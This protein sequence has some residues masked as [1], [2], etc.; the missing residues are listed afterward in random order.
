MMALTSNLNREWSMNGGGGRQRS[1]LIATVT[2]NSPQVSELVLL[3]GSSD[4]C[5]PEETLVGAS[6]GRLMFE[7]SYPEE[8]RRR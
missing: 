4:I 1:V 5:F 6:S 2:S 3:K 8:L 7:E